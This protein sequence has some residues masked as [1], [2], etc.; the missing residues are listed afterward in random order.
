LGVKYPDDPPTITTV[1]PASLFV[2][3]IGENGERV[4]VRDG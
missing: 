4:V 2:K 1:F 3:D